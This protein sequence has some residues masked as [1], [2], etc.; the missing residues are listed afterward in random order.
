M[1]QCFYIY[2]KIVIKQKGNRLQFHIIFSS[3]YEIFT[4]VNDICHKRELKKHNF[5]QNTLVNLVKKA[6]LP[7]DLSIRSNNV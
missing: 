1:I 2:V 3:I 4:M 5:V 6:M 7:G